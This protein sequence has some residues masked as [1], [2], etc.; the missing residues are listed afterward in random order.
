MAIGQVKGAPVHQGDA[1][2]IESPDGSSKEC[3]VL[4][5]EKFKKS[6][7]SASPGDNVG[8]LLSGIS[9]EEIH[10]ENILTSLKD[11]S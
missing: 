3:M 11:E 9:A 2:M 10:K 4:S 1:L 6:I 5:I 8:L 7:P